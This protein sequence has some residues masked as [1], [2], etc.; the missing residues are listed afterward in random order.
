MGWFLVYIWCVCLLLDTGLGTPMKFK[1]AGF[2]GTSGGAWGFLGYSHGWALENPKALGSP[3]MI[4]Q[5]ISTSQQELQD[6]DP[7][8]GFLF[9]QLL[10]LFGKNMHF[11]G[12]YSCW[13]HASYCTWS[14][15]QQCVCVC[16][17]VESTHTQASICPLLLA[18]RTPVSAVFRFKPRFRSR[19]HQQ[20]PS[21]ARLEC[22]DFK[23]SN[24]GRLQSS[25]CI[26][27][28]STFGELSVLTSDFMVTNVS[29]P[30]GHVPALL[31]PG[32][33]GAGGRTRPCQHGHGHGRAGG[34]HYGEQGWKD[35]GT[36]N[37]W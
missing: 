3:G 7:D 22:E 23:S 24:P 4:G 30:A 35:G 11:F 29:L 18:K 9:A 26:V 27:T 8:N 10:I 20:E 37:M 15:S 16:V 12:S 6:A 13:H 32:G 34:W 5:P 19:W 21:G 28:C 33:R 14:A 36:L 31:W 17:H 2:P 25:G 1:P